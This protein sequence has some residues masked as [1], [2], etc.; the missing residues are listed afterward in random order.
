MREIREIRP[1]KLVLFRGF[2]VDFVLFRGFREFRGLVLF[3]G[4]F[5]Y[6]RSFFFVDFAD[7]RSF[8]RIFVREKSAS[9]LPQGPKKHTHSPV[10]PK[11]LNKKNEK[12]TQGTQN[13]H[14]NLPNL[15]TLNLD[16]SNLLSRRVEPT[17]CCR[18]FWSTVWNSGPPIHQ[19]KNTPNTKEVRRFG[20][21]GFG[22]LCVWPTLPTRSLGVKIKYAEAEG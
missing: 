8:S 20:F 7:F 5:V 18:Y 2:F 6:F 17:E 15:L 14:P 12:K 22:G 13:H 16:P 10:L 21:G 4:F 1:G 11:E 9:V 19:I 3:S